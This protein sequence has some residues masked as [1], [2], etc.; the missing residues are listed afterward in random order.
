MKSFLFAFLFLNVWFF[1]T[2]TPP[3]IFKTSLTL[4]V[5]DESGNTVEGASVKLFEKKD[6][7]TKEV[8]AVEEATTDAKGIVRFKK[9]KPIAYFILCRKGDKDNTGGGEETKLEDGKFN[10]ATIVIQ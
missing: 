7:Y 1:P 6:D 3:Q 4:T 8:N 5:R 10:K 2:P 9:L